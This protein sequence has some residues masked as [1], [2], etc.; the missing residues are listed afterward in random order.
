LARAAARAVARSPLSIVFDERYQTALPGVPMDPGRGAQVLAFLLDRGLVRRRDVHHPIPPSLRHVLRTHDERYLDS[1]QDPA[2]LSAIIGTPVHD[3]QVRAI[4][5]LQRLV[6]GGT[7]QATRLALARRRPAVHLGGGL[8]HAG[9]DRGMGFCAFNDIAIAIR[10]LRAKGYRRPML[11]VDLDLHHGN[12]TRAVFAS[13]PTVHT[14]SI[15]NQD[16]D[17][18]P[19]VASTDIAL[20]SGV[21]DAA[22][23]DVLRSALPP[24]LA[25]HRPG[26]VVYVAGADPA[27]DDTMGD[28]RISAAAMLERD[29]FVVE[30]TR[31]LAPRAALVV[32]LG[33]GYGHGAWRYTARFLSWL[34]SGRA[35][36]PPD[37]M[38]LTLR[39]F[40]GEVR[41]TD[42]AL[43][44]VRA[45][46]SDEWRISVE[47][48]FGPEPGVPRE[49]RILGRYTPQGFELLLERVGVLHHLRTLGYPSPVLD[50]DFG[51]GL[52]QTV[53][54]FG[55]PERRHLLIEVRLRRDRRLVPGADVVFVEWLLLQNPR[56]RFSERLPPLP[57]QQHPGLG[58][59]GVIVGL[60][61]LIAEQAGI[62]GVVNVPSHYFVAAVGRKHLRFLDPVAQARF[63]T[64]SS[65]FA[66]LPLAEAERL[67]DGRVVDEASGRIVRWEPAPMVIPVS[68]RLRQQVDGEAY[69]AARD[70]ARS[71][72]RYRVLGRD[73][74]GGRE[75]VTAGA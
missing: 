16:W 8:H 61:V 5:D 28:W 42:R 9:P 10:R 41:R 35:L 34:A 33:G 17:D 57:G 59:L 11:V 2:V 46:E 73:T 15:H 6:A 70:A 39:R 3:D 49:T 26:L 14:L 71:R 7:I 64:L 43:A 20:G 74:G 22:Y 37:D 36:D 45:R 68:A 47:D 24:L 50:V 25:G 63:D 62:D 12:G 48:L 1:L 30:Q 31:T 44:A 32:V 65:L 51:S 55:E 54:V 52:G 58:L 66:G 67:L 29:R 4:L 27:A 40:R 53:R 38:E 72:L 69:R 18:V 19:A 23:L 56:A 60:L 13:D 21:T 75:D